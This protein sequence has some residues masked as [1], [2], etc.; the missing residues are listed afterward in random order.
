MDLEVGP[1]TL[2]LL[3]P[4]LPSA[5]HL[6]PRFSPGSELPLEPPR[7]CP[8]SSVQQAV[9][10]TRVGAGLIQSSPLAQSSSPCCRSSR[11]CLPPSASTQACAS[12]RV[13]PG[14]W[15]SSPRGALSEN[16]SWESGSSGRIHRRWKP[17]GLASSS[18][19]T[20]AGFCGCLV[21]SPESTPA[22]PQ[23]LG[24]R[25]GGPQTLRHSQALH[26]LYWCMVTW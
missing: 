21:L 13:Y 22:R 12:L 9:P 4:A 5:L 16:C 10:N 26:P 23:H 24:S 25:L 2:A 17:G 7:V 1:C 6:S 18:G 19:Q 20:P 15:V 11:K 8:T 14:A 3:P